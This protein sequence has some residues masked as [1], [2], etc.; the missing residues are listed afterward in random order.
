MNVLKFMYR[1]RGAANLAKRAG[2]VVT[3]FGP[4]PGRMGRRFDRFIDLLDEYECRPS[5]PITALPMQRHPKLTRHLIERGVE[6]AV[7]AFTHSDLAAMDFEGQSANIGKAVH[8]FRKLGIP[9][10]GFRAPYLHWNEDT[11]K[12]VE[13]YQF[14]YSSNQAVLW[15]VLD[16]E[17]MAARPRNGF[18]KGM[19]FYRPWIAEES[20]VLPFKRRGFVEI[21]VSLPDDEILLDRMYFH[22]PDVLAS[23]W[24]KILERT[25]RRGELFTV[26]LHPERI[27]FFRNSLGGLLA[28]AKRKK[29][30][31][32]DS[33]YVRN[34]PMVERQI[35]EFRRLQGHGR[36]G[37]REHKSL[38]GSEDLYQRRR[39]GANR[40]AGRAGNQRQQTSLRGG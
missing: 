15:N 10:C 5:F 7:H 9:F 16:V 25:Y 36:Q 2:Q 27:D 1:S 29:P 40:G 21:P 23:V 32:V 17:N 37:A 31:R 30:G 34:S 22:D 13:T 26:Q 11:M 33:H 6:L 20:I 19:E 8:I 12:V 3:R 24:E 38:Q 28:D 18:E 35:A 39:N 14:R 4:G